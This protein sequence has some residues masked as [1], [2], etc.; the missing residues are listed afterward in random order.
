MKDL[1][2]ERY[3]LGMEINRDRSNKKLWL[4]QSK[5]VKSVLD[6]FSMADC[7][8]LCV[9][10]HVGTNLYID[11]CPKY[12]SEME[13][14]SRV[15]YAS[16]VGSLMYAMVCTRLDISQPMGVLSWFMANPRQVHWDGVK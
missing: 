12:P 5:Y 14:M 4:S 1:G 3:I 6:R 10:I 9:P 2:V 16:T 11:H 15:P 8:P 7:R 13:D